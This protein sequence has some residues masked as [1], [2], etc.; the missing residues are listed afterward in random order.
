MTTGEISK[1]VL[2]PARA[3][4][5][6]AP[7][8]LYGVSGPRV[9]LQSEQ[10]WHRMARYLFVNKRTKKEIAKICGKSADEVTLV[11]KQP[12]FQ[13]ELVKMLDAEGVDILDIFKAHAL[14]AL[15]IVVEIMNDPEAGARNRHAA[16]ISILD[17]APNVGKPLVR[18]ETSKAS[19]SA[20][21]VAEA[22]R[23]ERENQN[24][25]PKTFNLN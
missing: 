9:E 7:Q 4:D 1:I 25:Q 8:R 5:G 19:T 6:K 16:A 12:W 22:E 17:R 3:A 24:L 15:N 2:S 10:P 14:E 23:L 18:I 11:F 20:D 13:E 21:P